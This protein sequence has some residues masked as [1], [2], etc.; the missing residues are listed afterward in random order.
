MEEKTFICFVLVVFLY[1]V[2]KQFGF[3]RDRFHR[4]LKYIEAFTPQPTDSNQIDPTNKTQNQYVTNGYTNE[5]INNLKPSNPKPI[6]STDG[7]YADT[8]GDF[9]AVL[10]SNTTLTEVDYTNDYKFT[11]EYPCTQTVTGMFTDCGVQPA[12]L[13]WTANPYKGL[14]CE[15]T[16]IKTPEINNNFK[17]NSETQYGQGDLKRG[18]SSIGNSTF[19]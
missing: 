12:N 11:V 16:N 4:I 14:Q 5:V 3:R 7:K 18:I 19:R 8:M 13:A 2:Y 10:N 1:F 17:T 9:P 15:L 6:N